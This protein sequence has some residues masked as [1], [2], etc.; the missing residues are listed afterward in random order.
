MRIIF[1]IPWFMLLSMKTKSNHKNIFGMGWP[2]PLFLI[3][4]DKFGPFRTSKVRFYFIFFFLNILESYLSVS[5]LQNTNHLHKCQSSQFLFGNNI[6]VYDLSRGIRMRDF[7][8]KNFFPTRHWKAVL[9]LEYSKHALP[10]RA[11][12]SWCQMTINTH[13]HAVPFTVL[14]GKK[15]KILS[16]L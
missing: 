8:L 5:P 15:M 9:N 14:V 1:Y 6:N 11:N 4:P 2:L 10:H 16:P 7:P 12:A 3:K 13:T